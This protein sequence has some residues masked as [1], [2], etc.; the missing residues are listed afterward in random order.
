MPRLHLLNKQCHCSV[1]AVAQLVTQSLKRFR[2]LLSE[3][4]LMCYRVALY[5][6]LEEG[7]DSTRVFHRQ[8][9]T[10]GI[11]DCRTNFTLAVH[12]HPAV[13][14]EAPRVQHVPPLCCKES[15]NGMY[16]A[17]KE[18]TFPRSSVYGL[19]PSTLMCHELSERSLLALRTL[20]KSMESP[21]AHMA[22][23]MYVHHVR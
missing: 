16:I 5:S 13:L 18:S 21:A 10:S 2:S 9:T 4:C 15:T 14:H 11:R 6:N 23:C 7:L 17:S 12:C 20:C 8:T 3:C 1:H 22:T 19:H